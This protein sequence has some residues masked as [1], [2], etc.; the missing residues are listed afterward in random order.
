M[1]LGVSEEF[2][3]YQLYD[4]VAKRVIVSK[5]VVFEENESWNWRR[6]DEDVRS[7]VFT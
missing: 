2:K 1:F 6:S 7:D 3:T 4:P 5:D